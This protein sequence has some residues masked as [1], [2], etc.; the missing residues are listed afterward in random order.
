M[1]A[2]AADFNFCGQYAIKGLSDYD[3]TPEEDELGDGNVIE[4][5]EDDGEDEP[6]LGEEDVDVGDYEESDNEYDDMFDKHAEVK[7]VRSLEKD[8]GVWRRGE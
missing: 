1:F 5:G 8:H 6:E 4:E 3:L 7:R 2:R